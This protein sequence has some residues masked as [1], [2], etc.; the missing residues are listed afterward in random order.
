MG[1]LKV[2]MEPRS[3]SNVRAGLARGNYVIPPSIDKPGTFGRRLRHGDR[4]LRF[5]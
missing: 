4:Y 3:F 2:D 5:G 1:V